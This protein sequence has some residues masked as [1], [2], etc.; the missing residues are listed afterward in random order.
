MASAVSR[1]TA[2]SSSTELQQLSWR[3]RWQKFSELAQKDPVSVPATGAVEGKTMTVKDIKAARGK[4]VPSGEDSFNP[5]LHALKAFGIATAITFGTAGL[6]VTLLM[7]RLE[8][9]DVGPS[10]SGSNNTFSPNTLS[11][12]RIPS[13]KAIPRNAPFPGQ[14]STHHPFLPPSPPSPRS[15]GGRDP[16]LRGCESKE[17]SRSGG[18]LLERAGGVGTTS[19]RASEAEE[20][21]VG[22]AEEGEGAWPRQMIKLLI[23]SIDNRFGDSTSMMVSRYLLPLPL[24]FD[25][26]V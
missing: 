15:T 18:D 5:A 22:G 3:Q 4:S 10:T 26:S 12:V 13:S 21:E 8:V 23:N 24:R 14:L 2:A 16:I 11:L 19:R 6:G 17:R 20:G 9:N 1:P 7:R 25:S